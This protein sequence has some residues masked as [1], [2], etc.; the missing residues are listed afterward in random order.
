MKTPTLVT[1]P[2]FLAAVVAVLLAAWMGPVEAAPKK[3]PALA[4]GEVA[5]GVRLLGRLSDA[6][7]TESSGVVASRRHPGTL[8]THNDG[9]GLRRQVLY[10]IDRAGA[11]KATFPL[12]GMVLRDWEDI[13]LGEEG[14]LYV[15]DIGN[16]DARRTELAVH[17]VDEPDP[18]VGGR[19]LSPRRSW[20]LAFPGAP[21]DCE[22]LFVWQ[23]HGFLVSKVFQD[24]RAQIYRF[25]LRDSAEV[26]TLELVATLR[27]QSPVTGADLSPD[28]RRLAIIAKNGA[29]LHRIDGDVARAGEVKPFQ[30]RF[31]HDHIEACTF[32]ADG[33]LATSESREIYLFTSPEFTGQ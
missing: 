12:V 32:V 22:G 15:G 18:A 13:A 25:A 28:G 27:V 14:R 4:A 3:A 29:Y 19:V 31:K 5:P 17:E 20:R 21:F 10:A 6:R 1:Q 2:Q 11:T 8:W 33:L 9:G 30:A 16:N 23:G 26:Q 24:A 7:L